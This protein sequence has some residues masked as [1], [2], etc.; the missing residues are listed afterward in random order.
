MIGRFVRG[1]G[2]AVGLASLALPYGQLTSTAFGF[3]AGYESYTLVGLAQF[4]RDT[5]QTPWLVYAVALAAVVGSLLSLLSVRDDRWWAF[6][7]GVLQGTGAA[8]FVVLGSLGG[9]VSFAFGFASFSVQPEV[10]VMVLGVA[11]FLSLVGIVVEAAPEYVGDSP[12][13]A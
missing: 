1:A 6:V 3:T 5:G 12:S 4:L 8:S 7:G 13:D 10:G 11:S 2:G 9:L